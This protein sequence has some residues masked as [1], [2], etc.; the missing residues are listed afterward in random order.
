MSNNFVTEMVLKTM[1]AQVDDG[2]G[3]WEKAVAQVQDTLAKW[4]IEPETYTYRNG[5][6][7]FDANRFSARQFVTV[8]SNAYRDNT[9]SPEFLAQLATGG[10]DGTIR[11]RYQGKSARRHV[12]AKTGTLNAVSALTGFVFEQDG[13]RVIAFSILVNKVDGYVSASR[14][15]QEKIVTQIA[16]YLN[17]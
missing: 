16:D 1:G 7:L 3:T 15:Y 11:S 9:I 4:G 6:G 12:R 5:S 2:P 17:K 10:V 8:L 13:P 14:A